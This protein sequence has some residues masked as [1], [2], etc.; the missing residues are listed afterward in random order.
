MTSNAPQLPLF[1]SPAT[2]LQPGG[3]ASMTGTCLSDP[4]S[5]A[6]RSRARGTRGPGVQALIPARSR[7]YGLGCSPPAANQTNIQV[8]AGATSKI[9]V[10]QCAIQ[11]DAHSSS[12]H[13]S[14]TRPIE[15]AMERSAGGSR[16]PAR[17]QEAKLA[18]FACHSRDPASQSG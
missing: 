15:A 9:H 12:S 17:R 7:T 4:V 6:S 16:H 14:P 2:V 1:F 5:G 8:A 18:G 10:H 3:K 13:F 11:Y